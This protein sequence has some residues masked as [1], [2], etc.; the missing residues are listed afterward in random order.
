MIQLD[1]SDDSEVAG[2]EFSDDTTE[3]QYDNS[4]GEVAVLSI[5]NLAFTGAT[6]SCIAPAVATTVRT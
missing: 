5:T 6:G 2:C 3:K 1:P 4:G